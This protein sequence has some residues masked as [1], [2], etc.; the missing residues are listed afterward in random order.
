MFP[1]DSTEWLDSDGDG[2]GDNADTDDDNDGV[3]DL[4]DDFPNDANETTDTDGDGIGDNTDDDDDGDGYLD[5]YD[6]FPLDSTEWID[7]DLDGIGNNADPDDDGDGWTDN[8]EFICGSDELDANDVPDDSD[9]DGICDSEDDDST[10]LGI[11]VDM[12]SNPLVV[13]LFLLIGAII[14]VTLFL[15]SRN[16]SSRINELEGMLGNKTIIEDIIEAE[17]IEDD[18]P[19]N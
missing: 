11:I 18:R 12:V 10:G 4:S 5:I 2:V 1:L 6:Q 16:Q 7:T 17:I 8:D 9:G 15:Q 19:I 13:G 3:P 14:I